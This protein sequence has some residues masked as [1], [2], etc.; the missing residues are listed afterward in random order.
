MIHIETF[1]LIDYENVHGDGLAGCQDLGRTDHIVIF[2]TQNAKNIDMSDISNHGAAELEMIEVPTG[3][4]SADMHIVSYLGF[5]AGTRGKNCNV[6]IVSRD[7]DF[8]NLIRFWTQKTQITASRTEQI[9]KKPVTGTKKSAKQPGTVK[10]AS[11]K[12]SRAKGSASAKDGGTKGTGRT[13]DGGTKG[14]SS[15]KGSGTKESGSTRDVGAEKTKLNKEV[16]QAVR[17]A[18]FETSVANTVA[19]IAAALYGSEQI[20]SDTHNAL[21]EKYSNYLEVYEAIKHVMSKYGEEKPAKD[22][23][24][25]A[26]GKDKSA[27]DSEIRNVLS[28]AGFPN[29]VTKYVAST[30]VKNLGEKSGKQQ[31]YRA[32]ISKYGQNKG[33]IIYNHIKKLI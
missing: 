25:N 14:V 7:T 21:R 32:V 27:A 33:L 2:F 23:G 26:S 22:D 30:A 29:D 24:S 15:A 1:Y 13:K 3:K 10:S 18:G 9:K 8:D 28:K 4:Q 16:M 11:S 19:Q 31:T 12:E 20:L 17:K 6:V 5:L